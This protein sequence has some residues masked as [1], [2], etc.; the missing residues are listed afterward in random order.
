MLSHGL[1]A[2]HGKCG[3]GRGVVVVDSQSA[4]WEVN[5][6]PLSERSKKCIFVATIKLQRSRIW[7]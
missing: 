4:V 1:G 6:T 3:L 2:A 7:Q 5:Y